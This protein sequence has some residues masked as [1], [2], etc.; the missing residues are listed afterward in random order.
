MS[1]LLAA[2]SIMWLCCIW[3]GLR[4]FRIQGVVAKLTQVVGVVVCGTL[5]FLLGALLVC[6]HAFHMFAG[7]TLVARVTSRP[8]SVQEFELTYLPVGRGETAA[9]HIRLRGD[10]WSISG[11]IVKWHPWLTALGLSSYHKPLRLSGQFSSLKEQRSH[12]P[13]VYP[14]APLADRIWEAFYWAAPYLPFI[15]A[16]YGSS[17]S[18]YVEP[19]VVQDIYVTSS[20][21]LIKRAK[22]T[23]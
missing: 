3:F 14:L 2:T 4:A 22:S 5:G 16:V 12:L 13:T 8:L 10:Q 20:G 15:D 18:V 6:L 1:S 17:A 9:A 7:E 11:G 19:S 23:F 21:Y